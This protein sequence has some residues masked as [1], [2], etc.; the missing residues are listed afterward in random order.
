[1]SWKKGR[2]LLGPLQPLLGHWR[3]S[4]AEGGSPAA[5]M[6]CSRSFTPFGKGWMRLEARWQTGPDKAYCETAFLGPGEDGG[7]GCFSFTNDGKRSVGRLADGSDVHA[8]AIAFEAQM[9]AGLA[10]MIYWPR[11]DGEPGFLFAVESKTK[12]DWNRFLTQR[13]GPAV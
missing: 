6:A 8:D 13:F 3:T 11:E 1:M 2:G 5:N 7:L 4:R 9:P 10:R 12:K